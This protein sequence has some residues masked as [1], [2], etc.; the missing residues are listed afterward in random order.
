MSLCKNKKCGS[1]DSTC[2]TIDK[3]TGI[4]QWSIQINLLQNLVLKDLSIYLGDKS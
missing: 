2:T 3:N 1:D 4:E